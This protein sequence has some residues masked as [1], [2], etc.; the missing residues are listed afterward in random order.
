M[1]APL[2]SDEQLVSLVRSLGPS[3][4]AE[5][6]GYKSSRQIYERIKRLEQKFGAIIRGPKTIHPA[7]QHHSKAIHKLKVENGTVLI[8]SDAHIWPGDLTTCQR[9]FIAFAKE[10][11]P[12]AI[13]I[14][15]D[16]VDGASVSSHPPIGFWEKAPTLAEEIEAVQDYLDKLSKSS[17]NSKRIWPAGNH[18]LRPEKLLAERVPQFR[19]I[20]GVHLRDHFPGWVPCWR[21]DV[22]DDVIIKH[23]WKG[24][25]HATHSHAVLSGK[26]FITGHLHSLK[27]N[28]WTDYNGTRYGVDTGTLAD[29]SAE[30]FIHYTEA[31]PTNWRSGFVLLTFVNGRLLWPELVCKFDDDSVEFRGKVIRV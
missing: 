13:V 27:V 12:A 11:K 25:I 4:A 17:R 28:P 1:G 18:D 8:G 2:C 29:P 10:F 7:T 24:G 15:G 14:N 21:L 22:N 19:N 23:R 5:H 9:A 3:K 30:Q 20:K 6:L 26:N 31:N 16:F